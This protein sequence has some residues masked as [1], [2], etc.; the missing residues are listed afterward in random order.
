MLAKE[1]LDI[2]DVARRYGVHVVKGNKAHCPFHTDRT[3]SMSFYGG[4]RKFHCFSCSAGGDAVDL[5]QMLLN[6]SKVEALRELNNAYRLGLDLDTPPSPEKVRRAVTERRRHQRER[7]LF[8]QWERGSVMILSSYCRTLR[9][10]KEQYAP[11]YPGEPLHPRFIEALHRLGYIEY[12]LDT[13]LIDGSK[14]EKTAFFKS[15]ERMLRALEQRLRWEG[16]DDA[17]GNGAG[18]VA[19]QVFRPVIVESVRRPAAAA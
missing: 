10:W 13:V 19:A 15:H 5:V 6:T 18:T 7:E 17:H 12:L 14:E 1:R 3:P 11:G 16:V 2:V 8:A 9:K 4:S